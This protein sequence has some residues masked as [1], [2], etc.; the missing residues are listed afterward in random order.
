MNATDR[1]Q[2]RLSLLR[3][4]D[5][6]KGRFGL[7]ARLLLQMARSEGGDVQIEDIHA[8]LQYLQDKGLVI[9]IEKVISPELRSW[10]IS[11]PGRDLIAP[12]E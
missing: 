5:S 2:L 11:G 10:R 9:Q 1:E 8:E 7:G 4:L 12:R 3:F 6:N